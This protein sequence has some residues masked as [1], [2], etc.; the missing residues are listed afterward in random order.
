MHMYVHEFHSCTCASLLS[1]L[2]P[3]LRAGP[4]PPANSTICSWPG[5]SVDWHLKPMPLLLPPVCPLLLLLDAAALWGPDPLSLPSDA[6]WALSFTDVSCKHRGVGWAEQL[7]AQF[8]LYFAQD[9]FASDSVTSTALMHCHHQSSHCPHDFSCFKDCICHHFIL[10]S[11]PPQTK[12]PVPHVCH[13]CIPLIS[14]I[15]MGMFWFNIDY[16]IYQ[17]N[18]K[19]WSMPRRCSSEKGS[20]RL[21]NLWQRGL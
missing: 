8:V 16:E 21:Q 1:H 17:I 15:R 20:P 5:C 18:W 11:T 13:V 2:S 7:L 9:G 19:F 12:A 6:P 3:S 10:P 4:A 14:L